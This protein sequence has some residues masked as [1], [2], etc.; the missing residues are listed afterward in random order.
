[1]VGAPAPALKLP[2]LSGQTVDLADFR[3]RSTLILFWNPNCQYCQEML[4]ELKAWEAQRRNN[5]PQLLLVA[6]GTAEANS[7]AGLHAPIVLDQAFLVGRAFGVTGTPMAVLVDAQ[8]N[9][10]SEIAAGAPAIT[11]LANGQALP[12]LMNV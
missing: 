10:A 5:W 7:A 6:T 1:M 9:I 4:P 12:A 8:G 11:A 3:G 2:D